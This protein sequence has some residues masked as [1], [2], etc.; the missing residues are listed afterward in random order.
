MR[1]HLRVVQC[2][3]TSTTDMPLGAKSLGPLTKAMAIAIETISG[4]H[5]NGTHSILGVL[6]F[7]ALTYGVAVWNPW[8]YGGWLAFLVAVA[9][10]AMFKEF[11]KGSVIVHTVVTIAAGV[12]LVWLSGTTFLPIDPIVAGV[13][14]GCIAHIV[15]DMLTKQGCPL[16][17]PI[18]KR[19]F[20]FARLT[21]GDPWENALLVVLVLALV[22]L[23]AWHTG[24]LDA[25]LTMRHR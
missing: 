11:R 9:S 10:A 15:G 8:A 14:L 12:G 4:G 17:W 19:R 25:V 2:C 16:L 24:A 21:T 13:A 22:G 5:R 3:Q 18:S 20:R 7:A 1:W 6:F 23:T